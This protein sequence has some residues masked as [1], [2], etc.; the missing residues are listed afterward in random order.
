MVDFGQNEYNSKVLDNEWH[1]ILTFLTKVNW[2][3]WN[4]LKRHIEIKQQFQNE[5]KNKQ[6][7]DK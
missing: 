2:F 6:Q 5:I 7:I 3:R 1:P 4:A